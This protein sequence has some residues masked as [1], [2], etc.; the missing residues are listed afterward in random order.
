MDQVEYD[1]S[2]INGPDLQQLLMGNALFKSFTLDQ[3]EQLAALIHDIRYLDDGEFLIHEGDEANAVYIIRDGAFEILKEEKDGEV[4]HHIATLTAGMSIGEV[5]LLDDGPRSASVRAVGEASVL[6]IQLQELTTT[7]T[8]TLPIDVQLTVRLAHNMSQRLRSTNETTVQTLREKLD[9]SE[10]RA[11]M[12]RFMSRVLIGTCLY[13]FALSSIKSLKEVVPDTTAISVPILIAF[14]VALYINIRTSIFPSSA[15]G[16]TTHNWK[17]AVKEAIV[18]SMPIAALIVAA[19]YALVNFYPPMQ[20]FAIF[21]FYQSKGAEPLTI[22]LA[23]T[24]YALFAPV[25]EMIARSGMQSSFMMFLTSKHK[26]W[27]AILLSTLLFSS[28]HLHVSFTLAVLVFPMGV[29]W[30][31]LYSRHPTLIGVGVSHVALGLFGLF[32]IGFPTK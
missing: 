11:E 15:Y 20:G 32:V 27:I 28:T 7:D 1:F 16:F 19:K 31:W 25:Q 18:F 6:V 21:D 13:M 22:A 9:E 2:P 23:A 8:S 14:A 24:F 12:G 29:F 26:K 10:T 5:S 4:A 3:F 17:P 30:G